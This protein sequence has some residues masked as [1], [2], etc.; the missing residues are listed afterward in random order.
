MGP[1]C[2]VGWYVLGVN[3]VKRGRR[4]RV[5][6]LRIAVDLKGLELYELQRVFVC[7]KKDIFG[8]C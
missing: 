4:D 1:A 6:P 8:V 7:I 5:R 3:F 2:E